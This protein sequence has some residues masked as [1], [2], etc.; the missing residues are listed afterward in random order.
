MATKERIIAM[1]RGDEA[2]RIRFTVSATV[3]PITINRA[4]FATIATAVQAGKIKITPQAVFRPGVGAE[5]H[6]G[7]VPGGPS[8]EL[9]VPPIFGRVQEGLAMH[10][11]THAFFDLQKIDITATEEEAVCYVVDALYFRMTGLTRPRWSNEP[12]KTAGSVADG[13]LRQYAVGVAGIPKV[14]DSTWRALVLA[15]AI[16]PT[17]FLDTAGL[18]H[19]FSGTDRYTHDG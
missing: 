12:H 3:G 4:T 14:D 1:L 10:E 17:Y 6:S 18:I 8:G 19:W 13:L 15:V 7:A 16:N 2:G 11:C 9:L 5:Y